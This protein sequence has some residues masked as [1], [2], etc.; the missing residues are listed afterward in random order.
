MVF[1]MFTRGDFS[2]EIV[3]SGRRRGGDRS[4]RSKSATT[5]LDRSLIIADHRWLET[6][7]PKKGSGLLLGG[8][9]PRILSGLVHPS[10]KWIYPTYPSE[11]VGWTNPFTKWDDPP[12]NHLSMPISETNDREHDD[13]PWRPWYFRGPCFQILMWFEWDIYGIR[14]GC[15]PCY[16][17]SELPMGVSWDLDANLQVQNSF[18]FKGWSTGLYII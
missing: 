16:W 3:R 6:A 9:I 12:S 17:Q 13:F 2:C 4:Q 1:C 18:F 14:M 11:I 7:Q 8:M 10:W 5:S 15:C